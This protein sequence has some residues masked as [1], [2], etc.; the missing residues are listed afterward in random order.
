[1]HVFSQQLGEKS[2]VI[3]LAV[4]H[5][6]MGDGFSRVSNLAKEA[7][8]LCFGLEYSGR[9]CIPDNRVPLIH[10]NNFCR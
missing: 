3:S 8:H 2:P 5:A 4:Q 6:L 10:H 1:M 7:S 9:D